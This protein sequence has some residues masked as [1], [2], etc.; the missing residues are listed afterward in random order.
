MEDSEN[1]LCISVFGKKIMPFN[2]L[3]NFSEKYLNSSSCMLSPRKFLTP[4]LNFQILY[5]E[6]KAKSSDNL[7]PGWHVH[8]KHAR[9]TKLLNLK[10]PL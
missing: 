10:P 7:A 1:L 8:M 9:K 4:I 5:L 2:R 6:V 3:D